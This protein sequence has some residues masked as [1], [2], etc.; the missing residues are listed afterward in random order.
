MAFHPDT[1]CGPKIALYCAI[2]AAALSLSTLIVIAH[3]YRWVLRNKLFLLKLAICGFREIQD[4]RGHQDFEYDVNVMFLE[5]DE[6]WAR[7][8]LL[9]FLEERFPDFNRHVFGEDDLMLGMHVL[10]A[11]IHAVE[12]SFKTIVLLSKASVRDNWFLIKFRIVID[13]VNDSEVES[14]IVI[15]LEDI[16][17]ADL[18]FLVRLYLSDRRPYIAWVPDERGRRYFWEELARDLQ[19]NLRRNHL[20]PTD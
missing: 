3:H 20:I 4:A 12:H 18:P 10:D 14:V 17:D 11:V 16:A 8:H 9:P 2:G 19:V 15:F 7:D 5:Q 1:E 13:F 6:Q